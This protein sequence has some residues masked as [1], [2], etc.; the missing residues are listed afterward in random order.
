MKKNKLVGKII[1]CTLNI[2]IVLFAI[3]L[4]ISMYTAVQVRILKNEYANFFGYSLFEVQTGSMHGTIEAGDW[5]IVKS[6]KDVKM[7]DI[8][9]YKHGKDFITHRVVEIYKGSYVT[10]GDANNTKDEPIDREQVVGKHVK[11][12]HGF[13]ILRKTIFNP[14]VIV[15]LLICLYLFN[16]TFKT[17]KTEFD[18]VV[19]KVIKI[20]KRKIFG[21]KKNVKNE[22]KSEKVKVVLDNPKEI[23]PSVP[24]A[25]LPANIITVVNDN[26]SL[27]AD[28][29][30][31]TSTDDQS[32]S[33]EVNTSEVDTKINASE[34]E[35]K[36]DDDKF[37]N[38]AM[39]RMIDIQSDDKPH[40]YHEEDKGEDAE[41][42]DINV[43]ELSKTS[44]F[45]II[46]AD[47]NDVD[48]EENKKIEKQK[49]KFTEVVSLQ[50]NAE[51]ITPPV[52]VKE[53]TKEY[54]SEKIKSKKAK[55]IID[56]TFII[57]RII[58]DEIL[59]VLL[60]H[61][62]S[63]I[64]KSP[65]RK[66]FI[67]KYMSLKY[68]GV[69]SDRVDFKKLMSSFSKDLKSKYI[70]DERKVKTID[71][72][73]LAFQFID[74][75]ESKSGS[76]DYKK[77]ILSFN[78]FEDDVL[79]KM[80]ND[81][82]NIVNYSNECLN[83]ILDK[84]DT[85]TFNDQY[86]KIVGQKNLYGVVLNHNISFSKVYSDYIVDKTYTEGI[87]AEDKI[88]V[89]LNLLLCKIVKDLMKH[90][91]DSKY[92]VYIPNHLYGKDKKL[93]K[94]ISTIDN[95]YAKSHVFF[96]T[97]VSNMLI[98]EDDV[99]RLSKKGY[100]FALSFNKPV[101][102]NSEDMGYIYLTDYYFIDTHLEVDKVCE[103]LPSEIIDKLIKE[104]LDKKI[105][106]Y[107]GD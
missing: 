72:Y 98:N 23:A 42:V 66:D 65:M 37:G 17:G 79:E 8:I 60:E 39:F 89:L 82:S 62:K 6:T 52:K 26:A 19:E 51:E 77:E 61:D 14:I 45:R 54:I 73:T 87:V 106:D 10:K 92:I 32:D 58:Y 3:F 34:S 35:T 44:V 71:A 84:L 36:V 11:T 50:L 15:S 96:L 105:G 41:V 55:N 46:S 102:F 9:T 104:N 80:V 7:N 28:K 31:I 43:D 25:P 90:D 47:S 70:R 18:L 22:I 85:N 13:G 81:I 88:A 24:S 48:K 83:E 49:E 99:K 16:L 76:I 68:F 20:I 30:D 1:D 2:L 40:Y 100:H 53:I 27:V 5:I 67:E 59:D 21:K 93:D 38:T 74:S 29:K 95:D 97:S 33:N 91:Y 4:L 78:E 63:Y 69:E 75:I 57:K 103:S 94:I 86:N 12:L 101:K 56:K 64:L 107:K